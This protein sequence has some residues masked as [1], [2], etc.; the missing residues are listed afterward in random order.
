MSKALRCSE[1]QYD[2]EAHLK[3]VVPVKFAT[4]LQQSDEAAYVLDAP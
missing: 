3:T 1:T 4:T 2:V